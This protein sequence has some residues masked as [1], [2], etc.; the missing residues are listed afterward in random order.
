MNKKST[1]L[2]LAGGD[3]P[4]R[5]VSL[6]SARGVFGALQEAGYRVL[7]ADPGRSDIAP[8]EDGAAVFAG[9]SIDEAPPEVAA[10]LA[11]ARHAFATTIAEY[12]RHG[13]D[14]VFNGLHGGAG[15][16]GTIQAVMDYLGVPYTGSGAAASALAMDKYRSKLVA[17]ALGVPAA[18][19]MV[20]TRGALTA[21]T[22]EQSVRENLGPRLVVKPNAQGSSVGLSIIRD[23]ADLDGAV[24]T[25]FEYDREVLVEEYLDG[26]EITLAVVDGV[27]DVPLLEVRPKS[28]WYDYKNKY[29][30][31]SCDYL[32][33]APIDA[34]VAARVWDAA[35]AIYA[36]LGLSV[37]ARIDFRV[38]PDGTFGLLE[39][40]TL[41]G[42]TS[43]S[44]V[45]K[46]VKAVGVSYVELVD[47]IVQA[48]LARY[49]SP[50]P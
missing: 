24:A 49:H 26:T 10:D 38:A 15:E 7:V 11:P 45:P 28:G 46:M 17:E 36:G 29:Q 48:S 25:A 40:N 8:T 22:L 44:L 32:V 50:T 42:M 34:S 30:S 2:V 3:S 14:M 19:G 12:R 35:H 21:G 9:A 31:G 27:R 6:D 39:A 23:Y 18:R 1:V 13:I 43:Q 37:Y 4:E 20:F 16:D 5:D 33:P 47:R 41:P